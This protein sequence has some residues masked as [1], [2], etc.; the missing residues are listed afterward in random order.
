MGNEY[1]DMALK[2]GKEQKKN[3]WNIFFVQ[4]N[5]KT[6]RIFTLQYIFNVINLHFK[7]L[8]KQQ[9]CNDYNMSGVTHW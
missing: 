4:Q 2:S 8:Q 3:I 7:V 5:K 9:K 6:K 1:K